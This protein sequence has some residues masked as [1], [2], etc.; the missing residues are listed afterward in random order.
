MALKYEQILNELNSNK[1]LFDISNKFNIPFKQLKQLTLENGLIT[2]RLQ[3]WV[4]NNIGKKVLVFDLETS[5]LP[6]TQGFG[7][8]Y[9][10]YQNEY[11][12]SSRIIQLS[13]YSYIIGTQVQKDKINSYFI[14]PTDNIDLS[15]S[16]HIHNISKELLIKRGM[17]FMDIL[18][19]GFINELFE[20]DYIIS[21]N[22]AFDLNVLKNELFRL[23]IKIP[24]EFDH[25]C[26]CTCKLT[27]YTKL[28]TLFNL[29]FPTES[30]QFH[31]ASQDVYALVKIIDKFSLQSK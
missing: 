1:N 6:S 14:N 26:V 18:S 30:I 3:N 24:S 29:N 12:N 11:Y 10:Y 13:F 7:K 25:K 21:H 17:K 5:G 8:F 9:P 2:H 16:F 22:I 15:Q 23:K 27:Y 4:V 31:D 20:C 19:L 28:C